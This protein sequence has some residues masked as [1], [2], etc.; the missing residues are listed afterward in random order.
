MSHVLFAQW[1]HRTVYGSQFEAT[2]RHRLYSV[3]ECQVSCVTCT[4]FAL[5]I[6]TTFL[7]ATYQIFLRHLL[8]CE[9]Y[10]EIARVIL[11]IGREI[12]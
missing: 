6:L 3:A 12:C 1:T 2:Y 11:Q 7:I 10:L 4:A 9:R 8:V 5:I